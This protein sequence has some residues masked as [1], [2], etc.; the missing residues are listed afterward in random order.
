M[1]KNKVR[2]AA[3]D[4]SR[5]VLLEAVEATRWNLTEA[6]EILGIDCG[7]VRRY[8]LVFCPREYERAKKTG[9]VQ[10]GGQNRG[11]GRK[12]KAA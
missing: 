2:Q 11:Q 1:L 6:G 10:H 9:L 12:R 4:A 5:K 8:L 7:S 3:L